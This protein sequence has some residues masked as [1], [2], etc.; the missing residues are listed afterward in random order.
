MEYKTISGLVIR[1]LVLLIPIIMGL[2]CNTSELI[3]PIPKYAPPN[4]V[5]KIIPLHVGMQSTYQAITW[6][7]AR[8]ETTTVVRSVTDSEIVDGKP[9]YLV[10]E[11]PLFSFYP[12]TVW[13]VDSTSYV[14]W[15]MQLGDTWGFHVGMSKIFFQSPIIRGYNWSMSQD[16]TQGHL[17]YTSIDTSISIC[18]KNY[19]HCIVIDICEECNIDYLY[20]YIT[21]HL[22]I[23]PGIGIIEEF[24]GEFEEAYLLQLVS[25][26]Y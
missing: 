23:A 15:L 1:K 2:S 24:G 21:L 11:T 7:F 6:Y 17:I 4:D 22:V 19:N 5:R 12:V 10:K 18:G 8:P 20:P 3:I 13:A 9:W 16:T 25:K 14:R 26:N